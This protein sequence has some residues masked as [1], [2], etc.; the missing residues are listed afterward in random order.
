MNNQSITDGLNKAKDI[1]MDRVKR[2]ELNSFI[3]VE[4]AQASISYCL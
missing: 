2:D 4:I 1:I 3:S